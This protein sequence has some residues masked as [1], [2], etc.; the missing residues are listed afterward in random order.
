MAM[1]SALSTVVT[2]LSGTAHEG[3]ATSRNRAAG[4]RP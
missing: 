4:Y 2:R 3:D 1:L